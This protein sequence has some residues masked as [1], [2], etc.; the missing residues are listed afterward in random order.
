MFDTITRQRSNATATKRMLTTAVSVLAHLAI[1]VAFVV[2]PLWYFTPTLP[3]PSEIMAFVAAPPPPPPPHRRRRRHPRAPGHLDPN[4]QSRLQPLNRQQRRLR[5]RL[6]S[7]PKGPQKVPAPRVYWE[8]SKAACLAA[9]SAGS[10]EA[11][12]RWRLPHLPRLPRLQSRTKAGPS[13]CRRR[14]QGACAHRAYRSG[15]PS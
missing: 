7:S 6:E 3:T 15:V 5:H 1:L 13:P 8:E 11:L 4:R 12:C 9:W 10:W 14:D 2:L